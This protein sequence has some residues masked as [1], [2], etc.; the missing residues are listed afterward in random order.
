M[1]ATWF[2]NELQQQVSV[3]NSH[4]ITSAMPMPFQMSGIL[5]VA[6]SNG[7]EIVNF[8]TNICPQ[9]SSTEVKTENGNYYLLLEGV[10]LNDL[11]IQR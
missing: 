3:E 7:T 4:I 11:R 5:L 6:N 1:P 2:N 9:G 10:N 8:V